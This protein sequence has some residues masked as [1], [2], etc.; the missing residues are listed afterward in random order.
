MSQKKFQ[1]TRCIKSYIYKG[2]LTAHILRKHPLRTGAT[3]KNTNPRNPAQKKSPVPK[4]VTDLVSIDTQELENMLDKEQE[5]FE[6][7]E[8]LEHDVGINENMVNWY[9]INFQSSFSNTGEF[10]NRTATVILPNHC[11][12]CKDSAKTFEKQRE[13]LQK[14]DRQL[15]DSY[16]TQKSSSDEMKKLKSKN[17]AIELQLEETTNLL[18]TAMDESTAEITALKAEIR[19]KNGLIEA[20]KLKNTTKPT[21][22]AESKENEVKVDLEICKKCG[23]STKSKTVMNNTWRKDTTY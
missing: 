6:A 18:E 19:T 3:K 9:D 2:G 10:S 15:Q 20:L 16:K 23:F 5:W 1:C 22:V 8:E 14:Q 4:T 7:V 13:L 12:D 17:K 21:N 11:K